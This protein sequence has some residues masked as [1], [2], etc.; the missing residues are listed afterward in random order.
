MN[1]TSSQSDEIGR[2]ICGARVFADSFRDRESYR[3]AYVT[4]LCQACQDATYFGVDEEQG[5]TIRIFDGAIVDVGSPGSGDCEL[6]LLPFRF[7]VP[8]PCQAR[9]VWDAYKLL[10][11]GPSLDEVDLASELEPMD[12]L[13]AGHQ[14][15]ATEHIAFESSEVSER[16]AGLDLVVGLDRPALDTVAGRCGL[17]D[18]VSRASLSD[19]VPWANQFGRSLRPLDSWWGPEPGPLSALRVCAVMGWLLL[20]RGRDGRRPFDHILAS[21]PAL[22]PENTR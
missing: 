3:D 7:V 20:E 9:C 4:G 14:L 13:L 17:P 1:A 16:V 12:S 18:G 10:R 6:A 11:I 15:R 19:E 2:C 5:R 21:H 22:S 8:A